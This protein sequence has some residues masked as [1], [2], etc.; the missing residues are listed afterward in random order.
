MSCRCLRR[1][2]RGSIPVLMYGYGFTTRMAAGTGIRD[3][4]HHSGEA[5][6]AYG[7]GVAVKMFPSL[8]PK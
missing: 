2:A 6:L 1:R 4:G 7:T 3:H 5:F 8:S